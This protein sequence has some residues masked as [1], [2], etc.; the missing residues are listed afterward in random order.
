MAGGAL[1]D[2][3]QTFDEGNA[4]ETFTDGVRRIWQRPAAFGSLAKDL[5][6]LVHRV[7]V[8]TRTGRCVA[9]FVAW[10]YQLQL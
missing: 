7:T 4:S 3:P 9:R 2:A 8:R 10:G 1:E 5:P 6:R